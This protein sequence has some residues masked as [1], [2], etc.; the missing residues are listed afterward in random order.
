M[1]HYSS[2]WR[3]WSR[4]LSTNHPNGPYI[5]V[6]LTS[7][8]WDTV[9]RINIRSHG[10]R[11]DDMD[12]NEEKLPAE[13]KARMISKLGPELTER[14]LTED[15]LPQIDWALYRQKCNG[16]AAFAEICLPA[17]SV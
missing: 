11:R 1:F 13:V 4:V 3:A 5:E 15:F 8:S 17:V 14:L 2:Y 10:T 7:M 12:R 16:G 6:D 9:A